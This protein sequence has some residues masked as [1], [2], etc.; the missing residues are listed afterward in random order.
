M[1]KVKYNLAAHKPYLKSYIIYLLDIHV[2]F[3]AVSFS[4]Y[5]ENYLELQ[6]LLKL[7]LGLISEFS[8]LAVSFK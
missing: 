2:L 1:Y 4:H 8:Y 7:S 3:L 6:K 5:K